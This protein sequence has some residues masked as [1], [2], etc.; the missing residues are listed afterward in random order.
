MLLSSGEC[1]YTCK[2]EKD[3]LYPSDFIKLKVEIDNS[4]CSKKIEKYKVKLLRRTQ[5]FNIK[6][7]APIYTNDYMMV[8]EKI[9]S[10]CDAKQSD[11]IAWQN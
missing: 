2:F 7:K 9:T 8:K 5:V 11:Q 1:S 6:T 10:S 3:V 4:K